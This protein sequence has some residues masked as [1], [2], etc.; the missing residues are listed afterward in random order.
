MQ[1]RPNVVRSRDE[2]PLDSAGGA[3]QNRGAP[4]RAR[5]RIPPPVVRRRRAPG[6]AP[7]ATTTRAGARHRVPRPH[8]DRDGLLALPFSSANGAWTHPLDRAVHGDVR[9]V[10]HGPRRRRHGGPTGAAVRPGG[11]P[12]DD[13][14]RRLRVHDRLHAAPAARRRP[15]DGAQRPDPRP[16]VGRRSRPRIGAHRA[17]ARGGVHA[18][19]GGHSARSR[20][21]SPSRSTTATPRRAPGTACS[22]R[23]R[24]ST[25]RAS[26]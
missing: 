25:T 1:H 26:T 24:R 23:S 18:D 16:G 21:A 9:G 22:T 8:R 10:R 3:E 11:D 17:A 7:A 13:P 12:G 19:R 15:A 2:P 6:R 4:A 14:A 5:A 20:S